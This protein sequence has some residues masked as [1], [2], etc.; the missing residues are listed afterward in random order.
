MP[1][2]VRRGTP[3]HA[4]W[5]A[6]KRDMKRRIRLPLRY[7]DGRWELEF[8]GEVPVIE[9]S[10]AELRVPEDSIADAKFRI[11]LRQKANIRI[12][13]RETRL[14]A[15]L[16]VK[17]KAALSKEEQAALL[18]DVDINHLQ[19]LRLVENWSSAP[20]SFAEVIIGPAT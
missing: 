12:L 9:G 3:D 19:A 14:L 6:M 8:G 4:T 18:T 11:R 5:I 17:D 10:R 1:T 16:N 13:P 20:F 7:I 2:N 15:C